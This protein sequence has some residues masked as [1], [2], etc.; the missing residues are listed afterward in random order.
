MQQIVSE[1]KTCCTNVAS[2]IEMESDEPFVVIV[3]DSAQWCSYK[4]D[5]WLVSLAITV[6][7]VSVSAKNLCAFLFLMLLRVLL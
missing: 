5:S 3:Y 2:T 1:M 4:S 6:L 7:Y